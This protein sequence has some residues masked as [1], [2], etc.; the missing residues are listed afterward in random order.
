MFRICYDIKSDENAANS[1]EKFHEFASE[2]GLVKVKNSF[3]MDG[4][5]KLFYALI[6]LV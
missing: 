2:S 1:E 3:K 4:N 6:V 5:R